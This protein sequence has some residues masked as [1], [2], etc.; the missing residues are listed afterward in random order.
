MNRQ[1][2]ED[3]EDGE[4]AHCDTVIVD[5]HHYTLVQTHRKYDSMSVN[6]RLWSLG[7]NEESMLLYPL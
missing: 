5:T 2:T 7:D 3:S 4:N 1:S 6:P